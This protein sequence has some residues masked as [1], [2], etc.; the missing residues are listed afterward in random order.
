MQT[1][2][3]NLMR[4]IHYFEGNVEIIRMG[5]ISDGY[6]EQ[7]TRQLDTIVERTQ[8]FT[9][10]AYTSHERRQLII[11]LC[12]RAKMDL[13]HLLRTMGGSSGSSSDAS[14]VQ[15][16]PMLIDLPPPSPRRMEVD[17]AMRIL[18]KTTGDLKSVLQ[19][20]ALEL[21]G[22]LVQSC[23]RRSGDLLD[24][25]ADA[26]LNA[27]VERLQM[28]GDRMSEHIDHVEDVSKLVRNVAWTESSHI[29]ARHAQINIKIYGPQLVNAATTLCKDPRSKIAKDNL[30]AF[31]DVW[32]QLVED[33][34][35][36]TE[37]V[38]EHALEQQRILTEQSQQ[39]VG[40]SKLM[41]PTLPYSPLRHRRL[42]D[43]PWWGEGPL[44]SSG[45]GFASK[46]LHKS[47][48]DLTG[49]SESCSA[50]PGP[51]EP[52]NVGPFL[53]HPDAMVGDPRLLNGD[54][55]RRH[56]TSGL[57]GHQLHQQHQQHFMPPFHH[58]NS[59]MVNSCMSRRPEDLL[60]EFK[61]VD[62][63]DIIKRAKKMAMQANDMYDFLRGQGK[64]KTTQDLFTRAEY[65]AEETNIIY[66]V[67][68]VFSYDVPSGEDKRTLM[69]IA[70]HVPKRCQQLQQLIQ[71]STV[72]KAATFTKVDS[73]I[74]EVRQII[75][76]VVTVSQMCYANA[77]KYNL[78]FSNVSLE[79]RS[80][81]GDD[82]SQPFGSSSAGGSGAN[83]GSDSS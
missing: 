2:E 29:R 58:T 24:A 34:V 3:T 53:S 65:F 51:S 81:A 11:V 36:V 15:S 9:D 37:R 1:G 43:G 20:T 54:L 19:R 26:A 60:N 64:V 56:S 48:P 69:A 35:R 8:D 27:D 40:A 42:D 47:V 67:I 33:F 32:L 21:A 77:N 22:S 23:R 13:T 41:P 62:N 45:G 25:L 46:F 70:D 63:N 52:S 31:S 80:T 14:G 44:L 79:G 5:M 61:D 49:F 7:L 30:D 83:S 66:K 59:S 12:E 28:S 76:L 17:Q 6:K 39:Q 82:S 78:D 10:S 38:A 73:I 16:A 50:T 18:L 68:R 55:L 71:S 75:N 74:R 72:G 57:P 4:S